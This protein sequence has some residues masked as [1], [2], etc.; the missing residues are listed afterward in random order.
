MQLRT[1]MAVLALAASGY[2][3][4]YDGLVEKKVFE[5]PAYTTV[6]GR[7]IKNVRVGYETYGRLNAAGDN[8]VFV[9]HYYSGNSHAAGRYGKD[10]AAPGYWDSII[11]PGKP[12]DT[13]KYFVI[14]AD[15]LANLNAKDPHTVTTGPASLDPDTGKPYALSFP[16]VSAR[17][18]VRVHRAL[19]DQLGVNR[20]HAVMGASGGS[21]QAFEWATLYP[22]YVERVVPVI[23]PGL[24]VQPYVIALLDAW[25]LPV[26]LDPA[27]QG[28]DYYGGAGP[29]AGLAE[30]LKLVTLTARHYGWM[31]REYG[32]RWAEPGKDPA[33]T[34]NGRF[35]VEDALARAGA[36]RARSVD[37]NALLYTS[38]A[39]QLYNVEAEAGRIRARVL[40]VPARSD[41]IFPPQM[42][43]RA[44]ERLRQLGVQADVVEIDGDG[45]H[46][47]G[48]TRIAQAGEA[49]RAFLAR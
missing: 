48:V 43:Y 46:L 3:Q 13:D 32:Y 16:V 31:E 5:M 14:S 15:T 30:S 4:A 35:L 26:R 25:A 49:I 34:L 41:L 11:G 37:A 21:M 19:L 6:G 45:G 47:D 40:L 18:F 24:S 22:D 36:A 9:A 8:A 20:L 38:K 12:V 23:S 42:S 27:W 44:A 2:A 1:W 39:Y 33:A 28:G 17:D 10:D 7:T 29:Q